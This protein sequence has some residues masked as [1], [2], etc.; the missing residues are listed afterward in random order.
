[1]R[2]LRNLAMMG[3]LAVKSWKLREEDAWKGLGFWIQGSGFRVQG[4]G[5]GVEGVRLR[6]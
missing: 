5:L 4:S 1:M 2:I 3:V 6:V